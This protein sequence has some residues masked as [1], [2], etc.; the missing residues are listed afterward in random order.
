MFQTVVEQVKELLFEQRNPTQLLFF[1]FY[2]FHRPVFYKT[3]NTTFREVDP[4][5]PSGE[6]R[7][8]PTQLGPLE[9]VKLNHSLQNQ[10]Y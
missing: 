10:K 2:F 4:S 3:E 8:T 7:K 1:F 6:R 5:P 9:R